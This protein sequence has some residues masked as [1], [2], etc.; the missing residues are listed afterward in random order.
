MKI[1]NSSDRSESATGLM[2][3]NWRCLTMTWEYNTV[4]KLYVDGVLQ[5]LTGSVTTTG[6]T[7]GLQTVRFGNHDGYVGTSSFNGKIANV[8]FYN[9]TLTAAEVL[10]NFNALRDRFDL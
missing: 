8:K 6:F 10:Q 9:R 3:T 7:Y 2:T 4:P 5:T 1:T